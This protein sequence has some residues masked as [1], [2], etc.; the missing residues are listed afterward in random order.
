MNRT[1]S[2]REQAEIQGEKETIQAAVV[3]AKG[4]NRYGKLTKNELQEE[5]GENE[6]AEVIENANG[7]IVHLIKSNRYYTVTNS[8][9]VN[10]MEIL[11]VGEKATEEIRYYKI[12]DEL[13]EIPK[14][15]AVSNIN[16]EYESIDNGI[17]IYE[18]P[19]NITTNS[20]DFWTETVTLNGV[21][22]PKVQTEY[23]QF[24]W[25]PVETAYVTAEKIT[26]IINN[27]SSVTNNQQAINYIIE[28]ENKYPMAVKLSDGNYRGILYSFA[29]EN[30]IVNISTLQFSIDPSESYDVNVT[31]YKTYYREPGMVNSD[32]TKNGD[33][34]GLLYNTIGLTQTS[35]QAEYN[36]MVESVSEN[37]GF[38]ISRYRLSGDTN[39]ESKR[40]KA[41]ATNS[42]QP[43]KYWY[44]LYDFSQKMY[45]NET[46]EIQSM[47][48]T[49]SQ[50]DQIMIW[51]KDLKNTSDT[52][53]YYIF[54][55]TNMRGNRFYTGESEEYKT[56]QIFDVSN[57]SDFIWTS[58]A[59]SYARVVRNYDADDNRQAIYRYNLV[60]PTNADGGKTTFAT[61]YI[62]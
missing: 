48:I 19:N 33:E 7:L 3:N 20:K 60:S 1:L 53:T 24:V 61:L 29:E 31:G 17:V 11:K 62:K 39:A 58:E 10:Q 4:R 56:K 25:V 44:G 54:N 9:K 18:I 41:M 32:Y 49:G 22:C 28:N 42:K 26:K 55:S 45:S 30:N 59:Y 51:M 12:D 16:G 36:A 52:S 47:M 8:G 43:H 6:A 46:Y 2:A 50:Y 13:I 38:Y 34:T 15:F 35:I 37:K 21:T 57:Q 23:N 27:N 5:L 14:G 40:G